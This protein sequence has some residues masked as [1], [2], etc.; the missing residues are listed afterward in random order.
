[1]RK[2]TV[3]PGA[4]SLGVEG[5]LLLRPRCIPGS[6]SLGPASLSVK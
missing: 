4:G 5:S 6:H 3:W 1:M 2:L